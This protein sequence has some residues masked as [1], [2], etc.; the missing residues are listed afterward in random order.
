MA[1]RDEHAGT[2]GQTWLMRRWNDGGESVIQETD[3]EWM[4]SV[5]E[6]PQHNREQRRALEK[7]RRKG[8]RSQETPRR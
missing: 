1:I 3:A 7:A 4:V 6:Q 5:P 8:R 2:E